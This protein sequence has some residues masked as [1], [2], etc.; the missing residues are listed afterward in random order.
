M[1]LSHTDA[2]REARAR[3]ALAR[4]GLSLHKGR[5]RTWTL[6]DYGYYMVVNE[7]NAIVAGEKY[8]LTLDA[9]EQNGWLEGD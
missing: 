4:Q 3:R 6:D 7:D 9:L 1:P 5:S 8:N 2:A